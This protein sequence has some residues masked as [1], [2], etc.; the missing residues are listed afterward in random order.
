MA[1]RAAATRLASSSHRRRHG[2]LLPAATTASHATFT[3]T[4]PASDSG[5]CT[6]T[7][8]A[9]WSETCSPG[10]RADAG[11][12]ARAHV[13]VTCPPRQGRVLGRNLHQVASLD[14][15]LPQISS[16]LQFSSKHPMS[17]P[18]SPEEQERPSNRRMSL[19]AA[20]PEQ[21][22]CE[23]VQSRCM[24]LRFRGRVNWE[25]ACH[26]FAVNLPHRCLP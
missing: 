13:V 16:K 17:P 11:A 20:T 4:P 15:K 3:P 7:R 22:K 23:E 19:S 9:S 1:L 6:R 2:H 21:S 10:A 24:F 12:R 18:S 26:T 8:R 25:V 14:Q 5:R